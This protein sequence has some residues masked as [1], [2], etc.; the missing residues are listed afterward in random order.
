MVSQ[1]LEACPRFR[2]GL[3]KVR[4]EQKC[5]GRA[6]GTDDF[7][8]HAVQKTLADARIGHATLHAA[9]GFAQYVGDVVKLDIVHLCGQRREK[10]LSGGWFDVIWG[11]GDDVTDY[12]RQFPWQGRRG[13]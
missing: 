3:R 11:L 6:R 13:G 7:L 2:T 9:Y 4:K 5:S 10:H 12:A 8:D 1:I